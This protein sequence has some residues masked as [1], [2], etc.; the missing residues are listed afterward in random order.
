[1]G[2]L[3]VRAPLMRAFMGLCAAALVAL[4]APGA[5]AQPAGEDS[6]REARR[7]AN[8][9]EQLFKEG[10]YKSAAERFRQADAHFHAPT[11][12]MMEARSHERLGALLEARALYEK[13]AT[14]DLGPSSSAK[15]QEAQSE[16]KKKLEALLS[17]IPSVLIVITR[18]PAGT[19]VTIDGVEIEPARLASP[20]EVNPGPR[21]IAASAAGAG[22]R[23]TV[24]VVK[25][26]VIETVE[27]SFPEA[28]APVAPAKAAVADAPKTSRLPAIIAFSAGGAGVLT[29]IVAG[30]LWA[31]KNSDIR[32]QCDGDVCPKS[33]V[34]DIEVTK[35]TGRLAVAGFVIGAAGA[36][37]GVVLMAIS[38]SSAGQ[39]A[40]AGLVIGPGS[41][42][43]RGSF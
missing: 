21:V 18:A 36:A 8:E 14:E 39:G 9:G 27:L 20:I 40:S 23:S 17:R 15:F 19:R 1:M 12:V 7:L 10:D 29:G 13:V 34:P 31:S 6:K 38:P 2:I 5:G 35:M 30:A 11:L 3:I 26:G 22:D 28:P 24:A 33:L 4:H 41:A 42:F 16:A 43:V 32:S 37:T 25:E